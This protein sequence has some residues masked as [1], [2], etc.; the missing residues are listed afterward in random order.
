MTDPMTLSGEAALE[1][2]A[3]IARK[4]AAAPSLD[5][6]LQRIV[7]LGVEYIEPCEG[8]SIS[9]IRGRALSTPVW[10]NRTVFEADR[11]QYRHNQGPCLEA[12]SVHETII[13]DDLAEE[14]RW[15]KWREAVLELNLRSSISFRLFLISNGEETFG[16][17]NMFSSR[18][19]AFDSRARALGQV[20]ASHAAVALKAAIT[21][22][23]LEQA[24]RSR[25]IIG[26]AKGVLMERHDISAD[27]ALQMLRQTANERKITIRALAEQ[28]T[29]SGK[30]RD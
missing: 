12:I 6:T 1:T 8:A 22:T 21:E 26:L 16:S 7:D 9:F 27:Q 23:G 11:A 5:E 3:Q 18:A 19:H 14:T 10:S 24:V 2:V 15:P 25:D 17:L 28:V 4:L 29:E 20:F 30:L 13:I